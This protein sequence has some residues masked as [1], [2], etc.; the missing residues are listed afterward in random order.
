M[1]QFA[2]ILSLI[3]GFKGML[4]PGFKEMTITHDCAAAPDAAWKKPTTV[5]LTVITMAGLLFAMFWPIVHC[6]PD[7]CQT[8][9]HKEP[10]PPSLVSLRHQ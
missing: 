10:L 5:T 6:H 4:E 1:I 8:Y 7:A 3:K 2:K 9:F